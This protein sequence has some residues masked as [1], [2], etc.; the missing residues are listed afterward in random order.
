MGFLRYIKTNFT[1]YPDEVGAQR[2]VL[3]L[4]EFFPGLKNRKVGKGS[5]L[6]K[7]K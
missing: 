4:P 6:H 1:R 5:A 2:A 7:K 3:L